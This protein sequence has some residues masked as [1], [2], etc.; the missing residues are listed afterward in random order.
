MPW[1]RRWIARPRIRR[2]D[3]LPP[4]WHWF[5]ALETCR[6]ADTGPDGHEA[7]GRFLPDPGLPRR[8]WAGSRFSFVRPVVIGSTV[9]RES[10][11]LSVTEKQGRSGRLAIVTVAHRWHDPE[12]LL[13]EEEQDIVYREAGSTTGQPVAAPRDE[14]F[15]RSMTADSL[16]LF[17][18]SALT[19]NGHRIHYDPEFCATEGYE[20]LVVHGPLLATLLLDLLIHEGQAPAP[21]AFRFRAMAPV[22]AGQ[23]FTLCGA[24]SGAEVRLWVRRHDGALAMEASATV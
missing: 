23:A 14:T 13:I 20:G 22:I 21:R 6:I 12:G 18:Y 7:L 10:Q 11:V 2:R 17:R 9:T 15:A 3:R 4:L 1:R 8:M 24:I 19:F 16:M 5:H